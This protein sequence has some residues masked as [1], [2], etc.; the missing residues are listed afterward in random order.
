MVSN[1]FTEIHEKSGFLPL[2]AKRK[3]SPIFYN[4]RGVWYTWIK[5]PFLVIFHVYGYVQNLTDFL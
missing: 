5:T 4:L 3:I 2:L 1:N